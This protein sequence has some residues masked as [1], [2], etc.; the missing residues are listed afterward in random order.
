MPEEVGN[1]LRLILAKK[2]LLTTLALFGIIVALA[3]GIFIKKLHDNSVYFSMINRELKKIESKV[4]A[5]KKMVREMSVIRQ[6]M[7]KRPLAID[8][9]SEICGITPNGVSLSM[10]DCESGKSVT[11]RGNAP[12]LSDAFKYVALLENSPVFEGVKVK[13]A[14]KRTA[15]NKETADFEITAVPSELK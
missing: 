9:V 15:E 11:V 3:L 14:N 10:I 8:I 12:S 4:A 7:S 2:N 1:E 13:Y 6:A 5:T